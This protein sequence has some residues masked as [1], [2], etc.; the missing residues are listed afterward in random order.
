MDDT[1]L[2]QFN[3]IIR[4]VEVV[5]NIRGLMKEEDFNTI[6]N[7]LKKLVDEEHSIYNDYMKSADKLYERIEA[8]Q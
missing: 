3:D 7:A 1:T 6:S 2:K 8:A 4:T 5:E